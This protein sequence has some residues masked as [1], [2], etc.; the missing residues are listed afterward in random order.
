MEPPDP[1]GGFTERSRADHASPWTERL[2]SRA[3]ER[4][5][6]PSAAPGL[7]DHQAM[8]SDN[9]SPMELVGEAPPTDASRRPVP[10]RDNSIPYPESGPLMRDP[11]V[12]LRAS[13]VIVLGPL[14]GG[15]R[16]REWRVCER[17]KIRSGLAWDCGKSKGRVRSPVGPVGPVGEQHLLCVNR[18]ESSTNSRSDVPRACA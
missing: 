12:S 4:A 15:G 3:S 7:A 11:G 2:R 5:Y 9:L 8:A 16:H 14:A 1:P 18:R 10:A 13:P 6:A 17:A